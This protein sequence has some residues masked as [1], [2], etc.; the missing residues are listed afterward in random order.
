[1]SK[2]INVSSFI[3]LELGSY[4]YPNPSSALAHGSDHVTLFE[5]LG[6]ILGKALYEGITIQPQFSHFFLSFM[7]G[8]YN[9]MH[10]LSDLSI[11]DPVL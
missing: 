5:F 6:R 9:F 11:M 7:R 2:L 4:L 1:M 8:D 3:F 10:M